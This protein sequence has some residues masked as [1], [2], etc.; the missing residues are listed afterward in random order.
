MRADGPGAKPKCGYIA[1]TFCATAIYGRRTQVSGDVAGDKPKRS[2]WM[3]AQV[4]GAD[5]RTTG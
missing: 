4:L 1:I 2:L 3:R 5:G